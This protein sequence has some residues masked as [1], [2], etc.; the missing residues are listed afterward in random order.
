VPKIIKLQE[1]H[2]VVC[3][4]IISYNR[5]Y[6]VSEMK[7]HFSYKGKDFEF[8]EGN[9]PKFVAQGFKNGKRNVMIVFETGNPKNWA[10]LGRDDNNYYN[11]DPKD[12]IG[13]NC[14]W[15]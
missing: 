8:I 5:S 3:A 4:D 14:D 2:V 10:M 11:I 12:T 15:N 13:M 6:K 9:T 1:N 7:F